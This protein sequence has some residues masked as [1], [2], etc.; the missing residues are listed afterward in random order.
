MSEQ[1]ETVTNTETKTLTNQGRAKLAIIVTAFAI[2]VCGISYELLAGTISSYFLGNAVLQYS[3]TIGVFLSAMG[4]GSYISRKFD[5]NLLESFIVIQIFVG[6]T[7]GFSTLIL[8]TAYE[9][10]EAFSLIFYA[11]VLLLGTLIGLEIPILMRILKDYE[12]LKFSISDILAFDYVGA[13]L[14]SILFPL[15]V[16]PKMGIMHASFFYGLM[17]VVVAFFNIAIFSNIIKKVKIL[18]AIA[19]LISLVLLTGLALSSQIV[20]FFEARLYSDE[21]IVTKQT[22]YQRIVLTRDGYDMRLYLDGNLQFSSWDEYRYHECLVHPAMNLASNREEV[23]ILGGGDGLAAREILK[24]PDVKRITLVDIDPDMV[25]FCKKDPLITRLNQNSLSDPKMNIV[26]DDAYKFLE[27]SQ[28]RYGVII[29]DLPDPNN[30]SLS[31][32][33]TVGYFKMIKHHLAK[34]GAGCIQSTSP[35]FARKTFWCIVH[36]IR[37]AGLVNKPFHA[38]VPSLSDWGFSLISDRNFDPAEIEIPDI[39]LKYLQKG[40]ITNFFYYGK[41]EEEVPTEINTLDSHKLLKYYEDEW[42]EW[43]F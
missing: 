22:K 23:L 3:L 28:E 35:Y 41:D 9:Y 42:K 29:G 11:F 6:L 13:L 5:K 10:T 31:K 25:E 1:N 4:V 20:S 8:Y 32:L 39:P 30:E 40:K 36:T 17:S 26:I 15:L 14:A 2:S 43:E 18:T 33:Y 12:A 27:K 34:G 37:E 24:Y 38:F 19:A 21:I 7:G 16:L